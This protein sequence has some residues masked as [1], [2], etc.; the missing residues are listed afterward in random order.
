MPLS[1]DDQREDNAL[2]E[3][4]LRDRFISAIKDTLQAWDKTGRPLP[5]IHPSQ[6]TIYLHGVPITFDNDKLDGKPPHA[7]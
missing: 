6:Q 1:D 4:R 2:E 7:P 3:Q 5:P